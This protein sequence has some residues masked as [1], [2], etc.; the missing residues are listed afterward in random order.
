MR[1]VYMTK[2][3]ITRMRETQIA[4]GNTSNTKMVVERKGSF[5]DPAPLPVEESANASWSTSV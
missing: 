5:Y 2:K 4:T 1:L 3:C